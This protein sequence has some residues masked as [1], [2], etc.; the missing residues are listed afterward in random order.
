VSSPEAAVRPAS[1]KLRWA[2]LYASLAVLGAA[3]AAKGGSEAL[4]RYRFAFNET[5]SLPYWAFIADQ[6]QRSPKRGQLVVFAPPPNPFYPPGMAFGKIV[7]GAPGDL[8][9]RR[10]QAFFVNGRFI[11]VAKAHA[12]DGRAV[13]PGPVGRI[14][15]GRYFVYTP[16]KDSL[17]S[18]YAVIGWIPQGRILGLATPVM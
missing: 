10:G 13:A 5:E 16:H 15:T 8:V 7:G 9:E 11:G 6:A 14:P 18:R 17:D 4:H 2:R 3:L 12:Q 1:A